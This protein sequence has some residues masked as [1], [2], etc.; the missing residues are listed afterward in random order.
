MGRKPKAETAAKS[1]TK[2]KAA[3]STKRDNET[4]KTLAEIENALLKKAKANEN[5]L[6]QSDIY[7]E[8]SQYDLDDDVINDLIEFFASKNVEVV[9]SDEEE[10]EEDEDIDFDEGAMTEELDDDFYSDLLI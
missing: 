7:D 3:K 2:A 5:H 4:L 1:A 9:S 8:L 10:E 6:E